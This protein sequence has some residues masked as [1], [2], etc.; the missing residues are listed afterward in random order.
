[1]RDCIAEARSLKYVVR[2]ETSAALDVMGRAASGTG[3]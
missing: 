1:M 3:R 2:E